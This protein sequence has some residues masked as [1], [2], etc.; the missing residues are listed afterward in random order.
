MP[1]LCHSLHDTITLRVLR[2]PE[3]ASLSDIERYIQTRI[4][5]VPAASPENR[6]Q[7][8]KEILDRSN[9]SFLWVR[10]VLD[11]LQQ[12]FSNNGVLQVLTKIP[13]RMVPYYQHTL[14]GL[15]EL[16]EK[17]I[18][19]AVLRWIIGST[20][21]LTATELSSALKLDLDIDLPGTRSAIEG[22]CGQL[23]S[24]HDQSLVVDTIHP[25][26]REFLLS[27]GAGEFQV[28]QATAHERISR[29]CLKALMSSD[30][31]P[32]RGHTGAEQRRANT[33]P[34][35]DY[36]ICQVFE[37]VN[38]A[39]SSDDA[40][41][42]DI[43]HFLR[44]KI[45]IW[46]EH[47]TR[48]GGFYILLRAS[49]HLMA[50]LERHSELQV[51]RKQEMEHL[52]EWSTDLSRVLTKFDGALRQNASAIHLLIPPLC[53]LESAI[54]RNFGSAPGSLKVVGFRRRA[55]DDCIA[56]MAMHSTLAY[57]AVSRDDNL[58]AVGMDMNLVSLY[59]NES[60][61]QIGSMRTTWPIDR[62]QLTDD[63]LVV[64]TIKSIA[65]H[66]LQGNQV[67]EKKL[68]ARCIL[69][70]V[71]EDR[72][73]GVVEHGAVLVW[74]LSSGELL[75][76]DS[77][78]YRNHEA[79]TEH[80][81]LR[82][83][84]PSMASISPDME[85]M[86]LGYRGGTVCL[87]DLKNKEVVAWALD[88]IDRQPAVLLFN[89]NPNIRL[90]FVGYTDHTMSLYETT[91]GQLVHSYTPPIITGIKAAACSTNGN[92]LA[93]AN[94]IGHLQIWDFKTLK[95][96]YHIEAGHSVNRSLIFTTKGDGIVDLFSHTMRIWS[97]VVLARGRTEDDQGVNNKAAIMST[98]DHR[99]SEEFTITSLCAHPTLP[100]LFAGHGSGTVAAYS[101]DTG[102]K[103]AMLYTH[104]LK[105]WVFHLSIGKNNTI[106]SADV[107]GLMIS[108]LDLRDIS[109]P[110][111]SSVLREERLSNVIQ[112]ICHSDSG[113]Y[114][115]VST[116]NTD[117]LYATI[118]GSLKDT[119]TSKDK[120]RTRWKWLPTPPQMKDSH[121]I[122]VSNQQLTLYC[123][124]GV[125]NPIMSSTLE[126]QGEAQ[127]FEAVAGAIH[128]NGYTLVL[129]TRSETQHRPS[130][131]VS[132]F[133][134]KRCIE[135]GVL[136]ASCT[137]ASSV[138]QRFLS[139]SS[140]TKSINFI[141]RNSWLSSISLD[142]ANRVELNG[143]SQHFFIPKEYLV[144]R[145]G[146]EVQPVT[147]K[148]DDVVFCLSDELVIVKNGLRF[149]D[150]REFD[151][152]KR[153]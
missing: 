143:Y 38:G 91:W 106:A 128:P 59:N 98:S 16:G 132:L 108:K 83:R 131:T 99:D 77:F 90:L 62:V 18:S 68:R 64:S 17:A 144:E 42:M 60:F 141:H 23:V 110:V 71:F 96:I 148:S 63:G 55:W 122:Q 8:A 129:E 45:L 4:E 21:K 58:I 9:A 109:S 87:W 27:E 81:Q 88:E 35:L 76:Q 2:V 103:Q 78:P 102:K 101:S 6:S 15:A 140:R 120:D 137:L 37:H 138:A 123:V 112:Q 3:T 51:Q 11:E 136:R 149:V 70:V 65:L 61:R 116:R 111:R 118:D 134:L 43:D 39:L 28:E 135:G 130:S 30:L 40:L 13:N 151:V 113:E 119:Q 66:D 47:L 115:I 146:L 95:L 12:V 33:S 124:D 44:T 107:S 14:V 117:H 153:Y 114:L 94:T 10:L 79:P 41:L 73:Y 67:W 24:V 56:E 26:V 50:Y 25:T 100:L 127:P 74:A 86:A 34:F 72:I 80:N 150:Q 139:I 52:G 92:T 105:D 57:N 32:I 104:P 97:P 36:A 5:G 121:F 46:I 75:S 29:V 54:H 49:K 19:K 84:A 126:L 147:T 53:P 7:L 93:T 31:Q 142:D 145:H 152:E 82:H 1:H 20:R 22:V 85:L 48:K 89:P 125:L 133:D 69:L